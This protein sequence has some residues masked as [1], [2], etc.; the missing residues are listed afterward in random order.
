MTRLFVPEIGF[1]FT[2]AENWKFKL[3]YEHRNEEL[4]NAL[5][6]GNHPEAVSAKAI[7]DFFE[8]KFNELVRIRSRT[9]AIQRDIN[10]AHDGMN[11]NRVYGVETIL[12]AGTRLKL[13]RIYI[14]KGKEDFSSLS[15]Y[16]ED[17]PDARIA[18][19]K[20]KGFKKGRMRFWARLDDCNRIEFV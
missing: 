3:F 1:E 14:R 2:L 18:K 6:C 20:A 8:T 7:Y 15:F 19:G 9:D 10:I 12:P 17:S 16:I 4:W 13:D 11:K 5:G